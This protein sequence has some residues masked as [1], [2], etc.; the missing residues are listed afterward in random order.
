MNRQSSKD[1]K[2]ETILRRHLIDLRD[3]V[4]RK[5]NLTI[6][7]LEDDSTIEDLDETI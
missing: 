4:I 7:N 6:N 3:K 5:L 2:I 1:N